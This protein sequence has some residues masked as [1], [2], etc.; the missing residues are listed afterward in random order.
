M[1]NPNSC[2]MIIAVTFFFSS[3]SP[4]GTVTYLPTQKSESFMDVP[5][6]HIFE[7]KIQFLKRA[8]YN[9]VNE[10]FPSTLTWSWIIIRSTP[11]IHLEMSCCLVVLDPHWCSSGTTL[12]PYFRDGVTGDGRSAP[13]TPNW[14]QAVWRRWR[15]S[16][17]HLRP[18]VWLQDF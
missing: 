10:I 15:L 4:R 16:P 14:I 7:K 18:D 12:A 13:G 3:Q 5:L 9:I 11:L 8:V 6:A 17:R 2:F 1:G